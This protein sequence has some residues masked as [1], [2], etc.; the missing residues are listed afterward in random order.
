MAPP[1]GTPPG[2]FASFESERGSLLIIAL[3][4]VFLMSVLVS[5]VANVAMAE[6]EASVNAAQVTRLKFALDAGF[7]IAK[8]N[9]VQDLADTDVDSLADAWAQPMTEKVA[10]GYGQV[11]EQRDSEE[12]AGVIELD[13]E[14]EDEAGKWPLPLATIGSNDAQIRRRREYLAAV[15]DGFREDLGPYDVD[16]GTALRYADQIAAFMTRGEGE[17][18]IVPRP[19]TKSEL[20]ILNVADLTLIKDIDDH[21]FFDEVDQQGNLIPGLLRFVTIWSDLKVNVNT[22][23]LPVLKGLFRSED[24]GRAADVYNY[25]TAQAEEKDKERQSIEGRFDQGVGR[26]KE[27]EENRTGGAI[28]EAVQDVQNV[29]GFTPRVFTEASQLMEVKSSVFS[30]WI[31]ARLGNL[32]RMRHWVVRREGPRIMVLLS[33]AIDPD[34]RPRFRERRPEDERR[35]GR[36]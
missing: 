2:R 17:A 16:S 14:I 9:L 27:D 6:Y 25:R 3:I 12:G 1:A 5:D 13:I 33:E 24:R 34:Y 31:T 11:E 10:G 26:D 15:I 23:P 28:F 18:G 20:H 29:E 7:E 32:V 36:R 22:A 21:V 8:A 4:V 19:S 30:V 35:D